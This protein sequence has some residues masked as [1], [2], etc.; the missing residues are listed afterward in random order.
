MNKFLKKISM[1]VLTFVVFV[2]AGVS[3]VA[4]KEPAEEKQVMNLAVNPSIELILDEEDKVISVSATNE[5]GA[6]ILEKFSEFT[7]MTAKDAALKFLELSEEY[8]FVVKGSTDGENLTISVSGEGAEKLY[9]DVKAKIKSKATEL[10]MN[11][12]QM[13]KTSK[14]NLETMVSE[15]YQE[16][17]VADIEDMS[18]KE[19]IQLI[20]KSREETKYLF[21]DDEKQAYYRERAKEVISAKLDAINEYVENNSSLVNAILTPLLTSM[22]SAYALL[23]NA[24]ATIN[25]QI[26]E[27][28]ENGNQ[29]FEAIN[30]QREDYIEL[31]KQYLAVVE[32]YN[33]AIALNQDEDPT[34][35]V[36]LADVS[37]A[38]TLLESLK[39]QAK[40]A[41]EDLE[42]AR[43]EATNSVLNYVK[44]TIHTQ[45]EALNTTINSI[46]SHISLEAEEIQNVVNTKIQELKIEHKNNAKNPWEEESV[47]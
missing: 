31:K 11:I 40:D 44:T 3:L 37:E 8:G 12:G 9:N 24:Y 15:C 26:E 13:V 18:E 25:A 16:Y 4:C 46:L 28:Y 5:D 43:Q 41:Q 21:T 1:L 7:G 36:D 29:S 6:Y 39:A 34:N 23:E 33:I 17:S 10:G 14:E 20:K 35:D 45:I 22:N 38:K 47:A 2:S 32:E 27:L 30:K 42:E 19:L